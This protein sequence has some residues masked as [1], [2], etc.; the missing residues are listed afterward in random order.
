MAGLIPWRHKKTQ[1]AANGGAVAPVRDFPSLMR[2]MQS[3]FDE[4]VE[5][6]T[7][8]WPMSTGDCGSGWKWGLDVEDKE[9]SIEVRAEALGFEAGDFDLRVS[10]DQ[11]TIR[12]SKKAETKEKDGVRREEHECYESMTLPSGIDKDKIES[13]YRNGVLTVTIPKTKE[14]RSKKIA[15][16]NA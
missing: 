3:E 16:K 11:L 6:F 7:S 5:R 15:V 14:G 9:E 4:L 12:A 10:G 2:R 8:E 1:A 13:R